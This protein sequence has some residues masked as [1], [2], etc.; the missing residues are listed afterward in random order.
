MLISYKLPLALWWSNPNMPHD[1][2]LAN[3][4]FN[5]QFN[6][7]CLFLNHQLILPSANIPIFTFNSQ[8][9]SGWYTK[10]YPKTNP[11]SI[12]FKF[13]VNHHWLQSDITM[14]AM[15]TP[16]EVLVH[17]VST[18]EEQTTPSWK[19]VSDTNFQVPGA[20]GTC[21]QRAGWEK[22]NDL[23]SRLV[24]NSMGNSVGN[25]MRFFHGNGNGWEFNG[26]N[27]RIFRSSMVAS[28]IC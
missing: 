12:L 6:P 15:A 27:G 17:T 16:P 8:K 2:L 26:I 5:V 7:H 11:Q 4:P 13:D 14:A 25:I 20:R 23:R 24:M 19:N 3:I 9:L 18:L 1:I 22:Y 10:T 21:S 28:I